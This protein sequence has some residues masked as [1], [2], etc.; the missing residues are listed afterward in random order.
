[1]EEFPCCVYLQGDHQLKI[2]NIVN[3]CSF[4]NNYPYRKLSNRRLLN[5]DRVVP[6]EHHARQKQVFQKKRK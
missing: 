3:V 2:M 4:Y 6:T 1:M 5:R